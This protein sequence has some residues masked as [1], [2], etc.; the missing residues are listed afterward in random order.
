[1]E[2]KRVYVAVI[3]IP[4]FYLLVKH[5][6]AWAFFLFVTV[7]ILSGLYEFY[8][9]HYQSPRRLEIVFGMIGGFLLA[10]MFYRQS[11]S[12]ALGGSSGME[13]EWVSGLIVMGLLS[14]LGG[15]L[16][17][18]KDLKNTLADGAV[19][20]LGVFYV[21]WLL[22]HLILLRNLARGEYLIFF[23]FLVTWSCDTGAYYTGRLLGRRPLAPQV[24]PNKTVEGA[25]GGM[26][27]CLASAVLARWWFLPDLSLQD[28]VGL[29]LLL[30]I[31]AQLGDLTESMFK[32]SAGVK[33]SGRLLPAH[34]GILDKVDSLI[35][36]APAFYYYM[37]WVKQYGRLIAV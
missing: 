32:R 30:G 16:F 11:W 21:S 24:S 25:I 27:G 23:V 22:G 4:L 8:R 2:L 36:T 7:G 13:R 14:A 9:M 18:K 17:G 3:F 15:Q 26:V 20:V 5:L 1:M 29:G 10:L 34:G 35:F 37:V 12:S 28:A 31:L 33:D 6:P 19:L